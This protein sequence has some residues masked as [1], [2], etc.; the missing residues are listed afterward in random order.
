MSSHWLEVS[1]MTSS[2]LFIFSFTSLSF[3]SHCP[4]PSPPLS[5]SLPFLCPPHDILSLTCFP[6]LAL[7][8]IPVRI[9][10]FIAKF[11]RHE[12]WYKFPIALIVAVPFILII[13]LYHSIRMLVVSF[14]QTTI[15][16]LDK[17][18]QSKRLDVEHG[19]KFDRSKGWDGPIL[20]QTEP[21]ADIESRRKA[22]WIKKVRRIFDTICL[23][24]D[25]LVEQ[26]F[27][28]SQE[29]VVL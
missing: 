24:G 2:S 28:S 7:F 8:S 21:D 14:K 9:I 10:E 4:L 13:S 1:V 26:S 16:K 15:L 6:F 17:F 12:K 20:L 3:A 22:M 5:P 23:T 19:F 11:M 29:G 25:V 18:G 27:Y